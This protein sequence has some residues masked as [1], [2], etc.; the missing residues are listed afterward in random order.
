MTRYLTLITLLC[1][2]LTSCTQTDHLLLIDTALAPLADTV[3]IRVFADHPG[4]PYSV[5]AMVEAR[6]GA[7]FASWD[8]LRTD[9]IE[10]ARSLGADGLMN[11]APELGYSG[12]VQ[13]NQ[14]TEYGTG[15]GVGFNATG[16]GVPVHH[17]V[18]TG[19]AIKLHHPMESRR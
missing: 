12:N 19:V 8:D 7:N 4:I 1:L 6:Q 13:F 15:S 14:G 2:T 11:L 16:I 5:V 10:E 17:K 3:P 18:L 9:L